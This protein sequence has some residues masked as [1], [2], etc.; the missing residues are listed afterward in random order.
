VSIDG[1]IKMYTNKKGGVFMN[2]NLELSKIFY[3]KSGV[4]IPEKLSSYNIEE[5]CNF[6]CQCDCGRARDCCN[7]CYVKCSSFDL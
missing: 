4:N 7:N 6:N 3:S 5:S 1:T 2:S